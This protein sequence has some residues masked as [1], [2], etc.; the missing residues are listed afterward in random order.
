MKK[1]IKLVLTFIKVRIIKAKIKNEGFTMLEMILVIVI[2]GLLVTS[3]FGFLKYFTFFIDKEESLVLSSI[4]EKIALSYLKNDLLSAT[5][6]DI[7]DQ[8][9][10]FLGFYKENKEF[11]SYYV[12]DSSS[13][14]ALGKKT[15]Q[16]TL[17]VINNIENINFLKYEDL[18]L[19]N[20]VMINSL[21]EKREVIKILKPRLRGD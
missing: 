17:A 4:E 10:S 16:K 13:G 6:I 20:F 9:I 14:L 2:M 3:S 8:S 11:Q 19:I 1:I 5:N 15:G 7:K 21:G 18:I 12:F